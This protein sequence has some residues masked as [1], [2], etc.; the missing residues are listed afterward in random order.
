MTISLS[1]N[2]ST[3]TQ[4]DNNANF[5]TQQS[6]ISCQTDSHPDIPYQIASP[7]P[8]IFGSK[9]C[10]YSRHLKSLSSSL[11]DLWN[12]KFTTTDDLLDAAEEALA[13]EYE[14]E[15]DNFYLEKKEMARKFKEN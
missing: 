10:Y 5:Q 7:L 8:P 12:V 2:K 3:D 9:L 1:S 14:K 11:P 15:V 6:T 13:D 4:L